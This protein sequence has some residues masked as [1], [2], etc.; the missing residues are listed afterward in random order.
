MFL[1]FYHY[2]KKWDWIGKREKRDEKDG[3]V[4]HWR[5][6]GSHSN[7]STTRHTEHSLLNRSTINSCLFPLSLNSKNAF[8]WNVVEWKEEQD[9]THFLSSF[10]PNILWF[11]E[12][13]ELLFAILIDC[14]GNILNI[15]NLSG[16][17]GNKLELLLEL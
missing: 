9:H 7:I 12:L 1:G 3:V 6:K 4:N 17:E 16:N 2:E 13:G 5:F 15:L 11:Y 8:K 14:K 10:L